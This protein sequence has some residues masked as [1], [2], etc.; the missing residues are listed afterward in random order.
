MIR[1][2][3]GLAIVFA[4]VVQANDVK[5]VA[6][7][8]STR[9]DSFNKKLILN[10]AEIARKDGAEVTVVNLEDYPIPLY[11]ADLERDE[12]M[13]ANAKKLRDILKPCDVII[14]AS[15]QYNASI[16]AVLKNDIDWASR[17]EMGGSSKDA[18]KGK[19]VVLLST[20]P[21]PKGGARGLNHL[22]DIMKDVGGNVMDEQL[23]V[24]N[25]NDAFD[26]QGHLK[27]PKMQ[28]QLKQLIDTALK[29]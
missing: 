19:T 21:G 2:F 7:A 1:W 24:P 17:G 20:S 22:R 6:F 5:V 4:S 11:D 23:S 8:G 10:A 18:F 9:K 13:P 14:I 15:P 27:D 3:V 12:K 28:S 25:A 29:K 16:P 26:A